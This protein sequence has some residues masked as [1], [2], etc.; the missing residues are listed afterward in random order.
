MYKYLH[1]LNVKAVTSKICHLA[2]ID[3]NTRSFGFRGEAL[4]SISDI[5][6]LEMTSKTHGKANGY[7][8]IIKV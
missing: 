2:D 5:A 1:N 4:S 3:G 6:L 8:K 7:R